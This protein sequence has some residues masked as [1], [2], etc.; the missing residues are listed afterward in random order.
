VSHRELLLSKFGNEPADLDANRAGRLSQRQAGRLRRVAWGWV[1]MNNLALVCLIIFVYT[2]NWPD[3]EPS[4]HVVAGVVAVAV[5]VVAYRTL[6]RPYAAARAGVVAGFAGP[7][8]IGPR[9]GRS[10]WLTVQGQA[11]P[12][13][14]AGDLLDP[15]APYRVY[16]ASGC[17]TVIAVEPDGWA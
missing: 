9:Q 13:P 2:F 1:G 12:S 7:V 14:I 11:F 5:L 15:R 8:V 10:L 6:R 4:Q 16:V 3:P 17:E